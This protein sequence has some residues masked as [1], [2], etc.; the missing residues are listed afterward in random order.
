[1]ALARIP[2][3]H[4]HRTAVLPYTPNNAEGAIL[5]YGKPAAGRKCRTATKI[6]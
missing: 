3:Q 2:K 4:K 1:M 6:S 5:H